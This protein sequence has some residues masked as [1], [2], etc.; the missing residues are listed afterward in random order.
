MARYLVR[1]RED[2]EHKGDRL[3]GIITAQ[4]PQHLFDIIDEDVNPC[5][6]EFMELPRGTVK[7]FDPERDVVF[8]PLTV[9]LAYGKEPTNA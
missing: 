1:Y 4:S 9:E 8:T 7:W 3:T 6:M 5:E 2:A